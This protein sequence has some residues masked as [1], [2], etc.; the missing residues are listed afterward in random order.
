M[1]ISLF[2]ADLDKDKTEEVAL[3]DIYTKYVYVIVHV[4]IIKNPP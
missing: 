4:Y 3:K 1:L 2:A